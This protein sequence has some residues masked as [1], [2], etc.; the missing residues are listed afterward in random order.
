[1]DKSAC[2]HVVTRTEVEGSLSRLKERCAFLECSAKANVNIVELFETLFIL[3]DLPDEMIP[4]ADRR[5]SLTQGGQRVV[6]NGPN[7]SSHF[8]LP[9]TH[10]NDAC[11][12]RNKWREANTAVLSSQGPVLFS[13][14]G[15]LTLRRR[16][17]DA[18]SA[19]ITNVRRPSIKAD[20]IMVHQKRQQSG[21]KNQGKTRNRHR[22]RKRNL[23]ERQ[24]SSERQASLMSVLDDEDP[25]EKPSK[26]AVWRKRICC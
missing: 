4:N 10:V 15:G 12:R 14:N 25:E 5:I 17:S 13:S 26:C 1:M 9:N 7:V 6:L 16:L 2:Q 19:L 22:H 3:A 21:V 24:W 23:E 18:Y 11:N 20:L 8:G